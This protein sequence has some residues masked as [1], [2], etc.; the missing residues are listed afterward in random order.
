ML[1]ALTR[2]FRPTVF[3]AASR[4]LR[5][6]DTAPRERDTAPRVW[7]PE[8]TDAPPENTR[9]IV[10]RTLSVVAVRDDTVVLLS[11]A[12][13][14]TGR[15]TATRDFVVRVV[16]VDVEPSELSDGITRENSPVAPKTAGDVNIIAKIQVNNFLIPLGF[17]IS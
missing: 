10:P 13:V 8:S 9:D 2:S 12:D 6:P 1:A 4:P 11:W 5:A 14:A 15:A 16:A 7:V 3:T 17:I